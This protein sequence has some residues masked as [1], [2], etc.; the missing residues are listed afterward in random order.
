RLPLEKLAIIYSH[1]GIGDYI[2]F[3]QA[4]IYNLNTYKWLTGEVFVKRFF[5]ELANYWLTPHLDGRYTIR[6]VDSFEKMRPEI[7]KYHKGVS[8]S[9]GALNTLNSSIMRV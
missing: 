6:I 7:V 8:G 4:I 5:Y 3:T 9:M 1:G 2:Q